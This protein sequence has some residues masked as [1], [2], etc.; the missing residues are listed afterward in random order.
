MQRHLRLR[1]KEDFA[2]LR[3]AGRVW[4]H[5]FLILSVAPN[6]LT[7]NRYGFVISKRLGTAVVRIRTRRRL[8]E[9]MRHLHPQIAPGHDI[10]IIAR[11]PIVEQ[12]YQT[13]YETVV[14][15]LQHAKLWKPPS[16]DN[17]T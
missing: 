8:R 17:V 11:N 1:R 13:L 2:H 7:H 9:V 3:Q 14:S 5:P 15:M 16:G 12:S 4:R 10:V 6:Q